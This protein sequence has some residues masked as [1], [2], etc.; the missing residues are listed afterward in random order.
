MADTWGYSSQILGLA[1]IHTHFTGLVPSS[2]KFLLPNVIKVVQTHSNT[3]W[4][5]PLMSRGTFYQLLSTPEG[6]V[7]ESFLL[8][9]FCYFVEKKPT[10]KITGTLGAHFFIAYAFTSFCVRWIL[11][12]MFRALQ[13]FRIDFHYDTLCCFY[14]HN[15]TR[16]TNN[17]SLDMLFSGAELKANVS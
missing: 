8:Y 17:S 3:G 2:Y 4:L 10:F 11:W 6:E 9:T 1:G 5:W 15:F 7:L 13:V 12:H 14:T 16:M